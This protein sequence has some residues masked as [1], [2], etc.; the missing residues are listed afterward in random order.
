V[1]TD[2]MCPACGTRHP[3]LAPPAP[4]ERTLTPWD[5]GRPDPLGRE[6]KMVPLRSAMRPRR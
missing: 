3:L 1:P 2:P 6:A 4:Y 5:R